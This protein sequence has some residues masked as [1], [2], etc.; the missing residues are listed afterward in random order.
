[1]HLDLWYVLELPCPLCVEATA[2]CLCASHLLSSSTQD[3]LGGWY[4]SH[5]YGTCAL[6]LDL[7]YVVDLSCPLCV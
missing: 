3:A 7:Y 5:P 1:M 2:A 4:V 6:H